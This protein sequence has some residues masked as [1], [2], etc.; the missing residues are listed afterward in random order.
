MNILLLQETVSA[1]PFDSLLHNALTFLYFL[2][3]QIGLWIIKILHPLFPNVS[4]AD[5]L[6]DPLGF[7]VIL[8]LFVLLARVAHRIAWIIVSL[9]WILLLVR[10]LML[11]F[12]IG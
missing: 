3:H 5:S 12:K 1:K 4:F 11:V 10:I 2:P 6:V 7:L 8:T 9:G